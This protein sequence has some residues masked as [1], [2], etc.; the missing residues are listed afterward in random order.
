[1][2]LYK[3]FEFPQCAS[4]SLHNFPFSVIDQDLKDLL[5]PEFSIIIIQFLEI[6]C[7]K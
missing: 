7:V 2:L 5:D 1:M 4:Q 6:G 3:T